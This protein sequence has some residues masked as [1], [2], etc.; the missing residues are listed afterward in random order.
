MAD[1]RFC[2]KRRRVVFIICLS[3]AACLFIAGLWRTLS[4]V[5]TRSC[6]W[7]VVTG[8]DPDIPP[9]FT[10]T[11]KMWRRD[12][13]LKGQ[14][15]VVEG[16]RHGRYV[17]WHI[18]GPKATEAF[19]KNGK[20]HGPFTV[21]R[22]DGRKRLE[23][24]YKN[25]AEH[26]TVTEWDLHGDGNFISTTW[27]YDS[28]PVLTLAGNGADI[29]P[30][31]T[32]TWTVRREDATVKEEEVEVKSGVRD[33]RFTTWYSEGRKASEGYYSHGKPHGKLTLWYEDGRK[34]N[35][36]SYK[37][38]LEHGEATDW[39]WDGNLLSVTWNY[40]GCPVSQE[41]FERLIAS[42]PKT[43]DDPNMRPR[44]N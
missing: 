32:G 29:P 28:F 8:D 38:G 11:W 14:V 10:G 23:S 9:W 30:G 34:K 40:E 21:W 20:L 6:V 33:G 42:E 16:V 35:E 1:S 7:T 22:R 36:T 3:F 27:K 26:G 43:T 19:Y 2:S 4:C 5:Y 39:D 24:F 17:S 37:E 31:F 25:G 15:D 18:E 13:S 41:E 44:D 12:G